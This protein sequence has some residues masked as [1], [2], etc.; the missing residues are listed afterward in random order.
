MA[1]NLGLII[2]QNDTDVCHPI[3]V[4]CKIK[5]PTAC[6]TQVKKEHYFLIL[7]INVNIFTATQYIFHII[8]MQNI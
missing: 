1:E 7:L 8:I 3:Y 5:I 2:S 4:Y 6:V